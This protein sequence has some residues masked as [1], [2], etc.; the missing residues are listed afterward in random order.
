MCDKFHSNNSRRKTNVITVLL[1]LA[2]L[3]VSGCAVH[4]HK[5]FRPVSRNVYQ[6]TGEHVHWNRRAR[7]SRRLQQRIADLLRGPLTAR[8]AEK[9]AL[10]N[11]P[12]LQATFAS[13]GVYQANLVQAGLLANPIVFATE[14]FPNR[15][16]SGV[17]AEEGVSEDLLSIVA[18]PLRKAVARD[19]LAATQLRVSDQV[20]NLARDVKVAYYR[21]VGEAHLL[22]RMKL[23]LRMDRIA[24]GVAAQQYRS[25]NISDLNY[26]QLEASYSQAV[27]NVSNARLRLAADRQRLTRL[28]GLWGRQTAWKIPPHLSPVP[29]GRMDLPHLEAYAMKHRYSLQAQ[30]K[31]ILALRTEL[32]TGK[33]FRYF[34]LV[35]AGVNTE[36]F[37]GGQNIT[38]PTVQA[39]LPVFDQNQARIARVKYAVVQA[40][41]QLRAMAVRIRSRVQEDEAR[42]SAARAE[43]LYIGRVLMPQRVGVMHLSQQMYDGMLMGV[44]SLLLARHNE[45]NAQRS[46]DRAWQDYFIAR[47]DLQRDVGGALPKS[48][49]YKPAKA[50]T[51]PQ[52]LPRP[53]GPRTTYGTD[54]ASAKMG[55]RKHRDKKGHGTGAGHAMPGMNMH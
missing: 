10:L 14:R 19:Q 55:G 8:T 50:H 22:N 53:H 29:A 1:G 6:R 42:L 48:F 36:K 23:I 44:Y 11:N 28:M 26:A 35:E 30:R 17:D 41:Q 7:P 32:R 46:Y 3:T 34:G 45:I 38:G 31:M 12:S 39:T 5:A 2:G 33:A 27:V 24:G 54:Q 52:L 18:M 13:V 25:G 4:G 16:P 51:V 43:A 15:P 21:Y 49:V 20:L 37:S 47:A 40:R 9:I